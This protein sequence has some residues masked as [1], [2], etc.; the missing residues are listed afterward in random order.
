MVTIRASKE[1]KLSV[2]KTA[3][4]LEVLQGTRVEHH[5]CT[6]MMATRKQCTHVEGVQFL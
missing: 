2:W 6:A 3:G 5:I 1:N 4:G